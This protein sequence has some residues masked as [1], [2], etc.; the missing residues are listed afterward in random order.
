VKIQP[1][2]KTDFLAQWVRYFGE[3]QKQ[4]LLHLDCLFQSNKTAATKEEP[5]PKAEK[6][7][8]TEVFEADIVFLGGGLS[9]LLAALLASQGF[10]V[11]VIERGTAGFSHR[12]WNASEAELA[13]LV[14]VGFCTPETLK[15]LTFSR[16]RYGICR[17]H[18]GGTYPVYGVLDCA[19]DAQGLLNYARRFNAQVGT[20]FL[21]YTTVYKVC[22]F[23]Q[24]V[25]IFARDEAHK[26][27][28]I[29][30]AWVIDGRGIASPYVQDTCDLLCPTVGGV[31]RGLEP[32]SAQNQIDAEIGEILVTTEHIEDGR[33][34]IWEAFPVRDGSVTVYLFYYC[35]KKALPKEALWSLYERFLARL[36]H[37]KIGEASLIKPTFGYIPGWSRFCAGSFSPHRRILLWGDAS[38]R[39]SPLTYCGFG[40]MLRSLPV[41][42]DFFKAVRSSDR[43]VRKLPAVLWKKL[44]LP[45]EEAIHRI[46]GGLAMLMAA[47]IGNEQP[48]TW[49]N[50]VLDCAFFTLHGLGNESYQ[51]M[52]Q[53][54]L[55][56]REMRSFL[57]QVARQ[58]PHVYRYMW[59]RLGFYNTVRWAFWI[60]QLLVT[61][62]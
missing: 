14:Q 35:Q 50:R 62:F 49:L 5:P 26:E 20:R 17:W 42:L 37:Y 60:I 28:K 44:E 10:H 41:W 53:D 15:A 1:L 55:T 22:P 24:H 36:G 21:E 47:P 45:R 61:P 43:S 3:E 51:A 30:A 56:P 27:L 16:Y 38:A 8:S 32:G 54:R 9:S 23:E 7:T 11:L 59:Q 58:Q 6:A 48:A 2:S 34:Y 33:Q 4:R 18:E 31:V 39:H 57:W 46:T 25:E 12:E 29:T 19:I 52:L 40:R 13:M